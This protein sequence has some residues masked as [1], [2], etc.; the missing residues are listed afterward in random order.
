[1]YTLRSLHRIAAGAALI[2]LLSSAR[3]C[4]DGFSMLY[5]FPAAPGR[6]GPDSAGGPLFGGPLV[7]GST[8]FG[9]TNVGGTN[10]DGA[11]YSY[12]LNTAQEMTLHSFSGSDGASPRGNLSV[13]GSTI[14]GTT[15]GASTTSG[16]VFSIDS[17]GAG[18]ANLVSFASQGASP[19]TYGVGPYAGMTVVGSSL[20]GTTWTGGP[21]GGGA[22]FSYD[23][24]TG[25]TINLHS[26]G[27]SGDGAASIGTLL[28]VGSMI[29]G[30]TNSGG[31][32][33]QGTIFSYN[34]S[35]GQETVLYTFLGSQN[36]DGQ[37]PISGVTLVGSTLYGVAAGG[38]GG[39][40]PGDA[41]EGDGIL[42]SLSLTT[43]QETILHYFG[44]GTDGMQPE[45][46]PVL[47]GSTLYGTTSTGGLNGDGT[48]YSYN[49]I[50]GAYS[51]VHAFDGGNGSDP[52]GLSL[53]GTTLYGSTLSGGP[54]GFTVTDGTLFAFQTPEPST[55]VMAA[56]G[57]AAL[58]TWG[59]RRRPEKIS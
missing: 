18:F 28:N 46:L 59:W 9:T 5:A 32:A 37:H 44:S 12:N 42:F 39:N 31:I 38:G 30:T 25:A 36:G 50:T 40:F 33:D 13:I 26:F 19:Y 48:I 55:D 21:S 3:L 11:I 51:V 22:L 49:I 34:L 53:S 7:V 20:V 8:L 45:G 58:A 16:S 57:L 4:A 14:Y 1:M 54:G 23:P 52:F 35:T 2:L 10:D 41:T 47:V 27:A 29:Y 24:N 43:G 56:L 15:F 17:S 6:F